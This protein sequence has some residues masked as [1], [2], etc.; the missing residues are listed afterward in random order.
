MKKRLKG[1]AE[2]KPLWVLVTG[3]ACRRTAVYRPS[4][5][6][7]AGIRQIFPFLIPWH[8]MTIRPF[9]RHSKNEQLPKFNSWMAVCQLFYNF[10]Y[11]ILSTLTLDQ[12]FRV[13][14]KFINRGQFLRQ[15]GAYRSSGQDF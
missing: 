13:S 12:I 3:R 1:E 15:S 10:M 4:H 14:T 5:V 8:V 6:S 11:Y 9:F 2:K 7:D